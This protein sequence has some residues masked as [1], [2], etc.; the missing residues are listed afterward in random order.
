MKC[1]T[2]N[3]SESI[4]ICKAC[5]KAVCAKCAID[6]GRGLA[7]SQDCV[8]EVSDLNAIVDKSKRIYSIGSES[9]LLPTNILM[10]FLFSILFFSWG[11]YNSFNWERIDFFTMIMGIG[12]FII[13]LIAYNKNKKLNLNC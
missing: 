12:F 10:Y 2:H 1:F 3:E 4:G 6:T 8:N 5:Q 13:G 11:V 7:C 9:K